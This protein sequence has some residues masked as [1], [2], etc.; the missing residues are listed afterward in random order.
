MSTDK[1]QPSTA[2]EGRFQGPQ[3]A[4]GRSSTIL[5]CWKLDGITPPTLYLSPKHQ[6]TRISYQALLL[7]EMARQWNTSADVLRQA[8]AMPER[9]F[10]ALAVGLAYCPFFK[11]WA[12]VNGYKSE[13]PLTFLRASLAWDAYRCSDDPVYWTRQMVQALLDASLQGERRM[14]VTGL[15]P[16]LCAMLGLQWDASQVGN[17]HGTPCLA[18]IHDGNHDS[19]VHACNQLLVHLESWISQRGDLQ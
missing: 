14:Q 2:I 13:E 12:W 8:A 19:L 3:A 9:P 5:A 1:R 10:A 6:P 17:K 16:E 7:Q 15:P 4:A 11:S 18:V